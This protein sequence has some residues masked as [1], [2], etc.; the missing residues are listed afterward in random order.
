MNFVEKCAYQLSANN[1]KEKFGHFMRFIQPEQTDTIIDIG[2]NNQ[3]Y[4][5]TDNFLEKH[6]PY[7]EQITAI[8]NTANNFF[9]Q[10]YPAINIVIAD[11][12]N[13]PFKDNEF[14]ISYSNAVLEHVGSSQDQLA[15]LKEIYRVAQ[16]GYLTTPNRLF[17]I[18]VHTRVPLLHII[19]PKRL[20][21]IFLTLIG[22][23][24]AAGNYM[25][26]LSKK[27][28]EE[29]LNAAGINRYH[30]TDHKLF[31][32]TVTHTATWIKD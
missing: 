16:R 14:N 27:Q 29:L 5:E 25:N 19:L 1:R 13:L 24:W 6:Y 32:F 10:K 23:K 31:G 12:R 17:P 9:S 15:F 2:V 18:E 8:S 7:P 28:L 3:E 26:L 11:G 22:K 21:D 20:F 4:S 30:I